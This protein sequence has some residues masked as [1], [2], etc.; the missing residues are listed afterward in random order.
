M[1]VARV[2]V[3]VLS[4][5]VIVAT[6]GS[7]VRTV[8]IPRG[9]PAR[10]ARFVF[11]NTRRLFRLRARPKA[12][13]EK[14]DRIM[15]LYA[16]VG[17]LALLVTWLSLLLLGYAGVFWAVEGGSYWAAVDLSGSS[18]L[19]LGWARPD[20]PAATILSFSEAGVGLIML[21]MLIAYLPAIYTVFSRRENMVAGLEVR[22]GSPPSGVEMLQRSWRVDRLDS[23]HG[24][25]E[26]WEEWFLDVAETHTSFPAV[27]FFRS[28][29][30]QHA[31]VTAAGAVLDGAA[32]LLS[33]VDRESDPQAAYC[34]RSGYLALRRVAEFFNIPFDPDP[35]PDDPIAIAREEFDEALED[36]R[37]QGLPL[38]R[39]RDRAWADFAGWRVNYDRVLIA[40]G[41]L[42]MA[43]LAPWSSDRS[44]SDWRPRGTLRE[45]RATQG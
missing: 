6:F 11:F 37:R 39:D 9:I 7:A 18:L 2:I 16:P 17:L 5:A 38:R 44:I 15:A 1:I 10:L 30:P 33:S 19:T 31:W 40:L 34:I 35:S 45:L 14:R 32:L 4:A 8:I 22:A 26:R 12:P 25:W 13:Y 24:V 41:G 28:P 43:P 27:V 21:A 3:G 20:D 42:T 36:L 29:V 23:L